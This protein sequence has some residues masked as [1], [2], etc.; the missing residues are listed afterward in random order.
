MA[1]PVEKVKAES[2]P[3]RDRR[4]DLQ[5]I[6]ELQIL[7]ETLDQI[8]E[9]PQKPARCANPYLLFQKDHWAQCKANCDAA[10]RQDTGD[11][12]AK[13][14]KE[15]VRAAMGKWWRDAHPDMKRPYLE[16]TRGE[17][18]QKAVLLAEYSASVK[19]WER[20]AARIRGEYVGK[21][22]GQP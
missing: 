13:A 10:R 12:E 17:K 1:E 18:E 4:Q 8:G 15:E 11:P 14:G 21:R 6:L 9:R 7:A 16:R 3:S 5:E 20:E 2:A 19:K 22:D